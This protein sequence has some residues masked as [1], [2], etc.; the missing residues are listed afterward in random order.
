MNTC[1]TPS[2]RL[3]SIWLLSSLALLGAKPS[4]AQDASTKRQATAV[5][6]DKPAPSAQKS[7][8]RATGSP[9]NS[10]L[11]LRTQ[12]NQMA[13]GIMAAE[14]ALAPDELAIAERVHTGVMPCE[15]GAFIKLEGDPGMPGYFNMTGKNFRYRMVPVVT[16]TGAIRLEDRGA[17]TVWLQLAN[18]S[19]LMNQKVGRR[20][21]DECMSPA[22]ASHAHHMKMNPTRGL[23]DGNSAS[24]P[25]PDATSAPPSRSTP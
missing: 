6:K 18:K 23:L 4:E 9:A 15:L 25:A 8:P 24:S 19:M 20:M 12:A 2:L 21:A 10:R 11:E 17:G 7:A 22:Q 13:A 14:A 16:S 5:K 1:H 3:M